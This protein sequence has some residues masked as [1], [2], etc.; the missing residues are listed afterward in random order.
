[1]NK[2]LLLIF[3]LLLSFKI[4]AIETVT[5]SDVTKIISNKNFTVLTQ[6]QRTYQAKEKI[7]LMRSNL[8]PKL[9][10]WKLLNI[11]LVVA[12]PWMAA[13]LVSDLAPFLV[14]AN[15]FKER[16]SVWS[17]RAEKEQYRA[18]WANQV[19]IAKLLFL[20][21]LKDQRLLEIVED[22]I[23]D[24]NNAMALA[25]NR[26]IM[27]V[28]EAHIY[29]LVASKYYSILDDKRQLD[30]L[31][32][33]EK[34]EL[35]FLLG[36]DNS[37]EIQLSKFNLSNIEAMP[38]I[39][40]SV[41]LDKALH[42]SPETEQFR[43]LMKSLGKAKA[44]SYFTILGTSKVPAGPG[45][46]IYGDIPMQSGL[47]FGLSP[48]LKIA[49]SKKKVLV[50]QLKASTETLKRQ[51]NYLT[52]E[53]NS[54][55]D[56]YADIKR[57]YQASE[58]SFQN[59]TGAMLIGRQYSPLMYLTVIDSSFKSSISFESHSYHFAMI[60]D[61]I[62]RLTFSGDYIKTSQ[63]I[64]EIL[65]PENGSKHKRVRKKKLFKG[66]VKLKN[67]KEQ[68]LKYLNTNLTSK[69]LNALNDYAKEFITLEAS[70]VL[71][72]R[73]AKRFNKHLKKKAVLEDFYANALF[74]QKQQED[75]IRDCGS[76]Y[77][78]LCSDTFYKMKNLLNVL[79]L[80]LGN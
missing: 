2:K 19:M 26:L 77:I 15:W 62:K 35:L 47:G 67:K 9:N 79:R 61:K 5:L 51:S 80:S 48:S 16:Q 25:N 49:K 75:I 56:G 46:G 11:P 52:E 38:K 72:K 55:I 36:M 54:L 29:E 39:N 70:L 50:L 45:N 33:K 4:F 37:K 32:Y 30:L 8:L 74:S 59:F 71:N 21:I 14:P 69:Y 18:V 64:G 42:T 78:R 73:N 53:Y 58:R 34:K 6:A 12:S 27:G 22:R 23:V 28:D 66:Y 3:S 10:L 43:L 17:Y 41:V 63:R 60:E 57:S 65:D 40:T 24:Y 44:S 76:T 1:M 20:T 31:I 68:I 13:G 7:A